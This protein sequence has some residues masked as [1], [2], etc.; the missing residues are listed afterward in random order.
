MGGAAE[1]P[2]PP[3]AVGVP[4]PATG[5]ACGVP[6]PATG[7][8]VG[9]ANPV[10]GDAAGLEPVPKLSPLPKGA[11]AGPE[12]GA[13]GEEEEP[14]PSPPKPNAEDEDAG[15]PKA[16]LVAPKEG[17]KGWLAGAAEEED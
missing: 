6:K 5:V 9:V 4:K 10:T 12:E 7:V 1:A 13:A 17:P 15:W 8:A 14:K 3:E 16:L 11:A 2:N